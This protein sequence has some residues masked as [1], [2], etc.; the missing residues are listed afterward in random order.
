MALCFSFETANSIVREEQ[1]EVVNAGQP[2]EARVVRGRYAY[3]DPD[4]QAVEMRYF[5]DEEGGYHVDGNVL[6][7]APEIPAEIQAA[8]ARNAAE[9][10]KLSEQERA[11]IDT[12][13]YVI[14]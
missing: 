7:Q 13:R 9:E 4:G 12:G 3:V 11:E 8:L 1:S 5:V 10:A 14:H 6:P 2:N